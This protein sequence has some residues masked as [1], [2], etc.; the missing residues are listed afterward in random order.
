MSKVM[1]E[2]AMTGL[3]VAA[4]LVI[5]AGPA[6]A[7]SGSPAVPRATTQAP[8]AVQAN[9]KAPAAT[10]ADFS[11]RIV[12]F[13]RSAAACRK[14]GKGGEFRHRWDDFDCYPIR[15]GFQRGNWVLKAYYDLDGGDDYNGTSY[16]GPQA[17]PYGG[18]PQS[19]PYGPQSSPYANPYGGGSGN[20]G[21]G[22]WAMN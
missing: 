11:E 19:D 14:I 18:A 3:A 20:L 4:G 1:R 10:T 15:H 21:Q 22:P 6:A 16:G 8:A 12:G 17:D 7:S 9:G 2:F 13:Y 5:G